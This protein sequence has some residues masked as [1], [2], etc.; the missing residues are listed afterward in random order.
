MNIKT[1]CLPNKTLDSFFKSNTFHLSFN[2]SCPDTCNHIFY[3]RCYQQQ[4]KSTDN[5][6]LESRDTDNV[7]REIGRAHV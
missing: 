4:Y 3:L 2:H 1:K 7:N 5:G 6:V